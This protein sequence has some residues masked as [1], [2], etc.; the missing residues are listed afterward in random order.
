MVLKS[1]HIKIIKVNDYIAMSYSKHMSIYSPYS[2]TNAST[3]LLPSPRLYSPRPMSV[4]E[5]LN[6]TFRVFNP[7]NGSRGYK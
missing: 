6:L 7:D 3:T 4:R 2:F 5:A 1:S